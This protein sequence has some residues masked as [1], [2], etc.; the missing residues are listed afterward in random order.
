MQRPTG[1]NYFSQFPSHWYQRQCRLEGCICCTF[2]LTRGYNI[3]NH[4][5]TFTHKL[6]HFFASCIYNIEPTNGLK[7]IVLLT[8]QTVAYFQSHCDSFRSSKRDQKMP[9]S[10]PGSLV[11][12]KLI[13]CNA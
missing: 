11:S 9:L 3:H 12:Q 7:I 2:D 13:A 1:Y 4:L 8:F 6:N 10:G 5:N